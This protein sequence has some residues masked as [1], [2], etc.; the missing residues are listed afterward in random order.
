MIRCHSL[1]CFAFQYQNGLL[2]SIKMVSHLVSNDLA[3]FN[4]WHSH[5]CWVFCNSSNNT[6][7]IVPWYIQ[8]MEVQCVMNEWKLSYVV[9]I[10]FWVSPKYWSRHFC[11]FNVIWICTLWNIC[12]SHI[13]LIAIL[14]PLGVLYVKCVTEIVSKRNIK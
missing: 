2:F 14:H 6:W 7:Y 3:Y 1:W 10:L 4:M 5:D 12:N 13:L 8:S 11:S 9:L